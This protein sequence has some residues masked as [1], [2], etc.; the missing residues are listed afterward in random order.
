[1][2]K[3]RYSVALICLGCDKNRVDSEVML[4]RLKEDGFEII[5]DVSN[6]DLIIVNTCG[7]LEDARKESLDWVLKANGLKK[8]GARIMVTGCMAQRYGK[9][10]YKYLTEA[11]AIANAQNEDIAVKARECL[12]SGERLYY[13]TQDMRSLEEGERFLSTPSHYAYL[14]I[15]DGCNNYCSYCLIPSI[16]GRYRSRTMESV[17]KEAEN[18]VKKG[19]KELIIV[20]QD[21]TKYGFD[22]YNQYALVDLLKALVKLDGLWKIRLL[23]CYPETV[24]NELLRFI[25]SEQ[26]IAKYIDI[27]L[28]HVSDGILCAMN[29]KSS[30][31]SIKILFD[32]LKNNYP[33][34]ALRS[35]FICGF[36]AES[37]EDFDE[38]KDFLKSYKLTNAGFFAF[39]REKGTRAYSLPNQIAQKVKVQRQKELYALQS[40]ISLENN[41]R[42]V[43]KTFEAIVDSFDADSGKFYC[44]TEFQAPDIDGVCLV[45]NNFSINI[46]DIIKIK[47]INYDN[48]DLTGEIT[49]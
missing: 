38:L 12:N 5:S 8:E 36:P 13:K 24:S 6:A 11:H 22:L 39:S 20:A 43:G 19:V 27:P 46:G 10:L 32:K 3:N 25:S 16:R 7:F 9:E 31:E 21:V 49:L 1:M 26:K 15:A 34:I 40:E 28:Q 29:R 41:K 33:Q 4:A 2:E 23:Y 47:I 30:G 48:Y 45:D 42:L 14:K 37:Q 44:R 18:L 35:T 17:L